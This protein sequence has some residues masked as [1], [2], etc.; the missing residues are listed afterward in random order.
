M[1]TEIE[2]IVK[3]NEKDELTEV[4]AQQVKLDVP[5]RFREFKGFLEDNELQVKTS[6]KQIAR[7]D[8]HYDLLIAMVEKG[9]SVNLPEELVLC[10]ISLMHGAEVF[11]ES[12][13]DAP[14]SFTAPYKAAET[15]AYGRLF[16]RL[17]LTSIVH[18][19]ELKVVDDLQRKFQGNDAPTSVDL[20]DTME[21]DIS[22]IPTREELNASE[23]V[24][25]DLDEIPVSVSLT[26]TDSKDDVVVE[27]AAKTDTESKEDVVV[28]AAAETDTESKEDV[29]VEAA[30][31]TDTESKEDVVVEAAA[32][33]NTE[34]KEDV[35]VEAA[36]ETN[37]ESKEDVVVEA[38]AETDTESK[39]DVVVE[40]ELTDQDIDAALDNMTLSMLSNSDT[41]EDEVED[42]LIDLTNSQSSL[43]DLGDLSNQAPVESTSSTDSDV[44][45]L[46]PSDLPESFIVPLIEKLELE[47]FA[48][49]KNHIPKTKE[50]AYLLIGITC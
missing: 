14:L 49:W 21:I 39:E 10:S 19:K 4:M 38:A 46:F 18:Q 8:K 43:L 11:M 45:S 42:D 7:T 41:S 40:A 3:I 1:K 31:E 29:V 24:E 44:R 48:D 34:S 5:E 47:Y 6:F 36:A 27:D 12:V 16:D 28:E 9:I 25:N 13:A 22:D 15:M 30:A 17:G 50:D 35:V 32:E 23:Q 37:T 26:Q 2:K 33:T 20:N